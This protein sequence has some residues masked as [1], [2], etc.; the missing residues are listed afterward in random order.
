[1]NV[2][3]LREDHDLLPFLPMIYVAWADGE[4]SEDE[5]AEIRQLASEQEYLGEKSQDVLTSWLDPNSPPTA[6]ELHA[7]LADIREA[8]A[9]LPGSE[10]R[11]LAE[12]GVEIAR[13]DG[14]ED[15]KVQRALVA[16]EEALEV[17]GSELTAQLLQRERPCP[18]PCGSHKELEPEANFDIGAMTDALDGPY[19]Q[20]RDE[21]RELLSRPVFSYHDELDK[22]TQRE[23]VYEWLQILAEEGIGRKAFP[24]YTG[25][26]E[27]MGEFSAIFETLSFFDL[28]LVIKFGVQFGLFGGSI[29][30]LGTQ[31]H[32]EAY[33]DE[34]ASVELPGCFAMTELGHGSNVRDLATTATFDVETQEWIIDTPNEM[35][36]KEWIGN[37]ATHGR[38]AT[39][40]AQLET[41]GER[42]GVHAFLVPIRGE[43]GEPL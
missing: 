3:A 36:R 26:G 37:A 19:K 43:D 8:A 32:H 41:Q 7:V 5:I 23:K 14:A 24:K 21:I 10:R 6:S 35:A 9:E 15:E 34:A 28:S 42:Y 38:M 11:S 33:L 31:K 17:V 22:E 16:L 1:M 39:V 30:F 12:L 29:Y 27:D 2:D 18:P 20:A 25:E 40:F 4:L 13:T